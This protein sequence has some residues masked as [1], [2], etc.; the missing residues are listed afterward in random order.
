MCYVLQVFKNDYVIK[1]CNISGF[2]IAIN[3]SNKMCNA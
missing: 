2:F 1:I 3:Y